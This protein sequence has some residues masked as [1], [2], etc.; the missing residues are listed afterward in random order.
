MFHINSITFCLNMIS[1]NLSYNV[2][3]ES[4]AFHYVLFCSFLGMFLCHLNNGYMH[5]NAAVSKFKF[6]MTARKNIY[7][8]RE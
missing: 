4:A 5:I 6:L 8:L 1:A 2:I 7:V 3:I